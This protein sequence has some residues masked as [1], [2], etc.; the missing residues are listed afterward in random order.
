VSSCDCEES[1]RGDSLQVGRRLRG[2]PRWCCLRS[3]VLAHLVISQSPAKPSVTC[4]STPLFRPADPTRPSSASPGRSGMQCLPPPWE[5]RRP[6]SRE[7]DASKSSLT[8]VR[9]E[10]KLPGQPRKLRRDCSSLQKVLPPASPGEC[11]AAPFPP[12]STHDRRQQRRGRPL[13][14]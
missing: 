9:R 4:R 10:Y 2:T 6:A 1:E 14:R 13:F 7:S 3:P 8:W 12:E 5:Y 11:S